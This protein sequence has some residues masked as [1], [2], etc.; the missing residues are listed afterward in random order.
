MRSANAA[1]AKRI[2]AG[3]TSLLL[4]VIALFSAFYLAAEAGHDCAGED[5]PICACIQRCESA[6]RGFG[7]GT[8]ALL[9]VAAPIFF[10]LLFAALFAAALPLETPVSRKVRLNN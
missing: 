2:A 6:L 7:G 5:C 9:S 10:I 8:A 4:L 1:K 3:V